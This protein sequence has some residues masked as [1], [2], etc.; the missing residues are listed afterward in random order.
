MIVDRDSGRLRKQ[1]ERDRRI[2]EIYQRDPQL[3]KLDDEMAAAGREGLLRVWEGG[4]VSE[5]RDR[6]SILQAERDRLLRSLGADERIYDVVWDCPLCQDRGYIRPGEPCR[7]RSKDDGGRRWEESGLSPLQRT[8]T[9]GNFSLEWYEKPAEVARLVEQ[10]KAFADKLIGGGACGNL[11]LFGPVGNGKTHLCSAV[12]NRVLE[13]GRTVA[14][15]GAEELLEA[16][17]DDI[18]GRGDDS[19]LDMRDRLLRADLL[20]LDDLG[21][22]RLTEFAED[23]LTNLVDQRINR[24]KP[25]LITSRLIGDKFSKRY[26]ARLVDRVLGE[27][28][29]LY[30]NEGSI[31]YKRAQIGK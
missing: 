8:Q 30:L 20:I 6:M 4:N 10:M 12:A 5:I 3:K 29:R 16:L 11:F 7:C 2:N 23:Q 15:T 17:R 28:K 25:W 13:A 1:E 31:R 24:Q 18:Y 9:F 22:E 21:T 27:G 19:R 26:D 14:Y